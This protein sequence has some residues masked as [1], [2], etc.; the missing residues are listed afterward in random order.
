MLRKA[1]NFAIRPRL[2]GALARLRSGP[3]RIRLRWRLFLFSLPVVVVLL[4]AAAKMIS[5]A[6]VSNSAISDF[7]GH[8]IAA[9]RDDV[10]A[11][12]SFDIFEPAKSAFA[13]ADLAVLE[14]RLDDAAAL[15]RKSLAHT[16]FAQSC[17]ARVNL[18]LVIETQG[19]L[20][21]RAG[22]VQVAEQRYNSA[23]TV[24]KEAPQGCFAGNDDPD[25]DRRR[26]RHEAL[27][28]LQQKL[29]KLH[30]P[31]PSS[32]PPESPPPDSSGG[33]GGDGGGSGGSGGGSGGSGSP[34]P[35]GEG[36]PPP[37]DQGPGS[38]P[39]PSGQGPGSPPPQ[40][41]SGAPPAGPGGQATPG[42]EGPGGEGSGLNPVSPDRLPSVGSPG[43][44][45]RLGTG[46]G[47]PLDR[48]RTLLDNSNASGG[49]SE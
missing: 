23:I 47:D 34:P 8:D 5:V 30:K 25:K 11:L 41:G 27:P 28:R 37:P 12:K 18:E 6:V 17:P 26:I 15:F 10:S 16:S 45:P 33:S 19:D 46:S 2:E 3:S 43:V 4:L 38:P 24:V 7:A 14:G 31:P 22:N 13:D 20:A 35:P 48:L 40:G 32:S 21:A 1:P 29:D 42:G 39:P 9:L 44:A 36:N 49:A